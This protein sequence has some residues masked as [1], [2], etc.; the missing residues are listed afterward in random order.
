MG[1]PKRSP[2]LRKPEHVRRF[3]AK[4][5]G[6]CQRKELSAD[7]LRALVSGLSLILKI[8]E[9]ADLEKRLIKLEESATHED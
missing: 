7:K 2:T 3:A 1:R 9:V 5:I 4:L 8:I 6:Q